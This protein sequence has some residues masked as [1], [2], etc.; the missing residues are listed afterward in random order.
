MDSHIDW[1]AEK[2][3]VPSGAELNLYRNVPLAPK[4]IIHI[5]HGMAEHAQRYGR[6]AQALDRAGYGCYA[7]DHRGHGHTYAD[8]APRGIFSAKHGWNTVLSDV[9]AVNAIIMEQHPKAPIICFGHSMGAII[10][11]NHVLRAPQ[12]VSAGAFWNAGVEAGALT[13]VFRAILKIE[14]F[15]KGSDVPSILATRLTFDTWNKAFAPNR[16]GFDW[17]SRDQAEVDKY[18]ADPLC[19][20]DV[21]IGLWLD[22]LDGITFAANDDNLRKLPA[23]LPIHLQAGTEDPCSEKS[24][25]VANIE[26]RMKA[27]G[28]TDVTFTPL[29]NTRHESLNEINRDE[30]TANFIAWLD[31][32]F[33]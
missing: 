15:F 29:Q 6:F 3:E 4:A 13:A 14:R 25:A 20:F 33:G 7:Q 24:I 16:T 26:T 27:L 21:S 12:T 31:S 17:L 19:G 5:N 23:N 22:V 8:D 9:A 2:H 10:A 28:M 11:F 1:L 30:T 32:R 18:V